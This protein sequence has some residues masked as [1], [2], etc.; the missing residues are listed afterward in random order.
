MPGSTRFFRRIRKLHPGQVHIRVPTFALPVREDPYQAAGATTATDVEP[1]DVIRTFIERNTTVDR[2]TIVR[3]DTAV[4][5][6]N[7]VVSIFRTVPDKSL[8]R[9]LDT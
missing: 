9:A 3:A 8:R 1:S 4:F 2:K 5:F 7:S 6:Q